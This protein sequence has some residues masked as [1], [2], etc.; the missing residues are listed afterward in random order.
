MP[1]PSL[2]ILDFS[3]TKASGHHH[4]LNQLI[5]SAAAAKGFTHRVLSSRYIDQNLVL[6]GVT[7]TFRSGVYLP[8]STKKELD[9]KHRKIVWTTLVDLALSGIQI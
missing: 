6:P 2:L 1:K 7:P 8:V 3:Y 9:G 4:S 5:S